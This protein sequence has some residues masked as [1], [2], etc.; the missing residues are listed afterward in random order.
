MT[1]SRDYGPESGSAPE[2]GLQDVSAGWS[3]A[4]S[5]ITETGFQ[6]KCRQ[7]HRTA[8]ALSSGSWR[9]RNRTEKSVLLDG[10]EVATRDDFKKAE[11]I[12]SD[13]SQ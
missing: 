4:G 5:P 12:N 2:L 10:G 7:E 1:V 3:L 11:N 9:C 6:R 13:S 8:L